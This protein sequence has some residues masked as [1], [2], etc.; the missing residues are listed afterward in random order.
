MAPLLHCFSIG[1]DLPM[2]MPHTLVA[3]LASCVLEATVV[4]LLDCGARSDTLKNLTQT[5]HMGR[6][7]ASVRRARLA[8]C[9]TLHFEGSKWA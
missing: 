3:Q 5:Q 7:N 8:E 1:S 4:I 6:E 2:L 9:R